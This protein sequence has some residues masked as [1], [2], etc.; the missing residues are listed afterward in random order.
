MNNRFE[1]FE[2]NATRSI[3]YYTI[4]IATTT[5]AVSFFILDENKI[6]VIKA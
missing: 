3:V 6:N 4:F 5:W 2:K 1:W